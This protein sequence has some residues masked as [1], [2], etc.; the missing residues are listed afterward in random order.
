M[1]LIFAEKSEQDN[2]KQKNSEQKR[3]KRF[4]VS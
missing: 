2:S 4:G 1:N 3:I